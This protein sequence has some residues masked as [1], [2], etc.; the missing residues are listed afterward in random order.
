[1]QETS[2][3]QLKELLSKKYQCYVLIT[4]EEPSSA[5]QMHVEMS[6]E[7]DPVLASYLLHGAQQYIQDTLDEEVED[8]VEEDDPDDYPLRLIQR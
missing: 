7:G 4:C 6:Y 5:G 3:E 2:D 8:G 1:M